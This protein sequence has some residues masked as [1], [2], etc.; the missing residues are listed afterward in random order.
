MNRIGKSPFAFPP[1]VEDELYQCVV[2]NDIN[3]VPHALQRVSLSLSTLTTAL[4]GCS[5]ELIQ[6]LVT[7]ID[8]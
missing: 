8:I 6:L 7:P 4:Q 2:N 5:L 1:S 3:G